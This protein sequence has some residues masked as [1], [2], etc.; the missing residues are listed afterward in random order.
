MKKIINGWVSTEKTDF[1]IN[2]MSTEVDELMIVDALCCLYLK[3]KEELYNDKDD[4][5]VAASK[6]TQEDINELATQLKLL[7][8]I[9]LGW[10]DD[11]SAVR[12][13]VNDSAERLHTIFAG[14]LSRLG[15]FTSRKSYARL[16]HLNS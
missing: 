5:C 14:G 10:A 7:S 11:Y 6:P 2:A 16:L 1:C 12:W 8:V 9:V 15:F 3:Q 4:I 13:D